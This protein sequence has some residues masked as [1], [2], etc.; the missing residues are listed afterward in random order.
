[1]AEKHAQL[2]HNLELAATAA[3]AAPPD[4]APETGPWPAEQA[5]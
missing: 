1:M 3:A 2:Q 5:S 4:P